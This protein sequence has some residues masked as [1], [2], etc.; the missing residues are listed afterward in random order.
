[1][2]RDARSALALSSASMLRALR[3][4]PALV[5]ALVCASAGCGGAT[6][7]PCSATSACAEGQACI[8]GRCRPEAAEL[9]AQTSR[10]VV[11]E[12]TDLAVLE[13]GADHEPGA[14]TPLGASGR[15]PVLLI[16]RFDLPAKPEGKL[17]SAF[18]VFDRDASAPPAPT[19]VE[20][21]LATVLD[22]WSTARVSWANQP[23]VGS[24]KARVVAPAASDAPLRIEVT[25]LLEATLLAIMASRSAR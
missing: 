7:A 5:C 6:P 4:F 14:V 23:R 24:A 12:P 16:V 13:P 18:L 3:T 19:P 15:E 25:E 9:A 21:E 22:P 2:K 11:L 1:M 20:L 17:E 10:R 8:V